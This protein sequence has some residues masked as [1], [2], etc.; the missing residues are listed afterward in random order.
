MCAC[1]CSY[2]CVGKTYS[3]MDGC[4]RWLARACLRILFVVYKTRDNKRKIKDKKQEIPKKSNKEK[5]GGKDCHCRPSNAP[6]SMS[7]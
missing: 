2:V 7:G 6:S 3:V 4:V 1:Q 5:K